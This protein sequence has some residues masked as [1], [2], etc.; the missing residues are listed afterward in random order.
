MS[1]EIVQL[2]DF[3]VSSQTLSFAGE[4]IRGVLPGKYL[5]LRHDSN[6]DSVH[7]EGSLFVIHESFVNESKPL[8]GYLWK[9][10]E[11]LTMRMIQ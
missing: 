10:V 9:K 5:V 3:I 8:N 1:D 2:P 7:R 11:T 4:D 6:E